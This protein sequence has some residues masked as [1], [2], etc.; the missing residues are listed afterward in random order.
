MVT[1]T[2]MLLGEYFTVE[3]PISGILTNNATYINGRL[4]QH[5][6]IPG[7]TG[8]VF[9]RVDTTGTVRR[10][11]LTHGGFLTGTSN[12]TRTSPVKRGKWVLDR[13]LCSSP[14]DPPGDIDLNIDNGAEFENVSVRER[15]AIHQQKGAGCAGCHVVMDAIGLGLENFDGIGTYR[16][17]DEF[18][19]IDATGELPAADG[20]GNVPFDGAVQ[21]ADILGQDE[22]TV[23]CLTKNLLTFGLGRGFDQRDAGLLDVVSA[24]A[25]VSGGSFRST[26]HTILLSVVFQQRRAL[27]PTEL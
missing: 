19:P 9:Q 27:L 3:A 8:D 16:T 24:Y 14:P 18:G 20:S 11:L 5:Y 4:A 10:G 15:L 2:L 6:G 21:L 26:L 23:A 25:R 12:P 13:M 22:R 7:V 17:A 1:E